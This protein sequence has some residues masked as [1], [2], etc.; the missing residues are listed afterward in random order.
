MDVFAEIP[1]PVLTFCAHPDDTEV[2]AGGTI[3]RLVQSRKQVSCVL[4]TSGNRGTADPIG[5]MEELAATREAEQLAASAA[6]GLDDVTFLHF[7][8][9]DLMYNAHRLRER[10]I[11]LVREKRPR[12]V[13]T[14]DPWP[15]NGSQD[16]C[17]VYPDHLTA[18]LAAFEAAFVC[19]PGPLFHPEHVQEGLEPWK[20]DVLYLIMS[21]S[22]DAF[23]DISATWDAKWRA[24][25]Q[26]RSQGRDAEGM[27]DFF[28]AIAVELGGRSGLCLAE[29][30]RRLLPS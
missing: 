29:G 5:T 16:A 8:D 11:R 1:D 4:A 6:L 3:A 26:H 7:D 20:P 12:T 18:G 10:F 22:P 15:G 14:H 13:I 17:S 25:R 30:F 27:H 23:V 19:S 24:V 2:H 9:G 28:K 21:G